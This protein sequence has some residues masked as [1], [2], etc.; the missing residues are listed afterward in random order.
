LDPHQSQG[1][2]GERRPIC[3]QHT[4]ELE[5]S[6]NEKS[7]LSNKK[8]KMLNDSY[9]ETKSMQIILAEQIPNETQTRDRPSYKRQSGN[10]H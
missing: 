1:V 3:C 10:N 7:I 5:Q 4:P 8:V 6:E 9:S 2:A